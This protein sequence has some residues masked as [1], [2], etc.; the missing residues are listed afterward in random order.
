M[1]KSPE[2]AIASNSPELILMLSTN[3][4]NLAMADNCFQI[5]IKMPFST[6]S[7]MINT[8]SQL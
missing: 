5:F 3:S 1:I 7:D 4:I 6:C 2:A 8:W